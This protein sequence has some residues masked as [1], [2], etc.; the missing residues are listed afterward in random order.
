MLSAAGPASV[1]GNVY[2]LQH[3]HPSSLPTMA[4]AGAP[5]LNGNATKHGLA[6]VIGTL[7]PRFGRLVRQVNDF[8]KLLEAE[9]IAQ[10]GEL[11]V[12]DALL[13]QSATRIERHCQLCLK[14]LRDSYEKLTPDQRLA[15]SRELAASTA[16]RDKIVKQLGIEPLPAR[17]DD[18]D[19]FTARF[20]RAMQSRTIDATAGS[21]TAAVP[22]DDQPPPPATAQSEQ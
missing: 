12:V 6:V 9:V 4:R 8:R 1:D 20:Q 14:W 13:V 17:G 5:K 19:G 11:S 18:D 3:K 7:P 2:K 21:E 22:A 10:K 15:H 16:N